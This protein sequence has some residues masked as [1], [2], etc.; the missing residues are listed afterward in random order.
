MRIAVTGGAGYIG[1]TLMRRLTEEGYTAISIDN[2]T[3]G[4]Y[5]PLRGLDGSME[6]IVG[7]IR[8][9]NLLMEVF[10]D[11]DAIIH[12]AAIPGLK[13]CDENPEE[14][15]SVNIYGTNQVL[16]AAVRGRCKAH[17]LRLQRRSLWGAEIS[18]RRRGASTK[19]PK[20]IRSDEDGGGEAGGGLP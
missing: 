19:T 12:L 15:I 10:Q 5:A 20:P 4:D 2:L 18:T 16:R 8:D 11:V 6:L 13:A 17:N 14:A 7:D 3:R 1:S 9:L